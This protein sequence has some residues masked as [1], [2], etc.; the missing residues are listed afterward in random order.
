M[1]YAIINIYLS[2]S[3]HVYFIQ[4]KLCMIST[5]L[6]NIFICEWITM[7]ISNSSVGEVCTACW[8]AK[9]LAISCKCCKLVELCKTFAKCYKNIFSNLAVVCNVVPILQDCQLRNPKNLLGFAN[10]ANTC[11]VP[12]LQASVLQDGA[13]LAT[14]HKIANKVAVTCNQT[15]LP[16]ILLA[17][18][19]CKRLSIENKKTTNIT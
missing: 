18:T 12:T 9:S 1:K 5:T 7:S 8:Q 15:C 13:N 2:I 16:R 17:N 11:T 10:L 6:T 4:R 19:Q 14:W 3:V